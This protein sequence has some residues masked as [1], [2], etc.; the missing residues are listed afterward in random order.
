VPDGNH[1]ANV[2][3]VAHDKSKVGSEHG[4][5]VSEMARSNCGKSKA[6][7]SETPEPTETPAPTATATSDDNQGD[8]SDSNSAHGK[9]GKSGHGNSGH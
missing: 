7:D 9:S 2:S 1:G 6:D 4:K 8:S 3:A 5:A